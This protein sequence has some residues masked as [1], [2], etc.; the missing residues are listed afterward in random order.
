M[1]EALTDPVLGASW[2][3]HAGTNSLLVD[4]VMKYY[5]RKTLRTTWLCAAALRLN[6]INLEIYRTIF[7]VAYYTV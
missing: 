3:I 1:F 4:R 5:L 7:Q 6:L 2:S